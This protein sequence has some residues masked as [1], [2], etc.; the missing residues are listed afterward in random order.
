MLRRLL[1]KKPGGSGGGTTTSPPTIPVYPEATIIPSNFDINT[2]LQPSGGNGA[3]APVNGT[4]VNG[5]FRY[6]CD[7]GALKPDDPVIYPAQPT[8]SSLNQFFGNTNADGSSTYST[9]RQTGDSTCQSRVDRSAYWVPAMYDGAGNVVRPDFVTMEYRRRPNTDTKCQPSKDSMAVGIC[10]PLPNGLRY[11]IGYDMLSS[12]TTLSPNVRFTCSG[13]TAVAGEHNMMGAIGN[14][15]TAPSGGVYNRFGAIISSPQ[16]WDGKNLDSAD[17]R[18]HVAYTSTGWLGYEQCPSTHPY[19]IPSFKMTVWYTVDANLPS[20]H[21]ASDEA[22]PGVAPGTTFHAGWFGGWD[23]TVMSMW[24]QNCIDKRLNCSGGDLGNGR[25][26]KTYAGFAYNASPRLVP[27]PSAPAPSPTPTPSPSSTTVG[28]VLSEGDSISVFWN[29]NHTGIYAKNH[30]SVI[31]S[32]RAVGG[33][34]IATMS[35]RFSAD[36]A[37]K[38]GT[39]TVL[40][41]ANDLTGYAST[42]DW[43][44]ALW[45]YTAQWKATGAKVVV[46]TVLPQCNNS[47]HNA[48]RVA[49]NAAIRAAL[50]S[51][52]DAV[53]DYAADP[54]MGPDAAAC[55]LSLYKDGLHPTD[56]ETPDDG[57]HK[58]AV[59]YTAALD[60]LV[61]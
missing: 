3:I 54:V 22:R 28:G 61:L 58:L 52:I 16:C 23:N 42:T 46:G 2:E 39:V 36:S 31:F 11:E 21:F 47:A 53:A 50:G 5:V 55:N 56:Y 57:Q 8:A 33:S 32:G 59:I 35:G 1:Q 29:G 45:A 27:A 9:L 34:T 14:C 60:K 6:A 4:D 51:K 20:W 15:P 41:G 43:L 25:Q 38:P 19:Y 44:N 18:S 26:M 10:I 48:R 30:P 13:P 24:V 7:A 17:H 12:A 49:A 40:I 37:V